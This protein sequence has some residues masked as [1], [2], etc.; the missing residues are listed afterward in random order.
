MP[1][2]NWKRCEGVSPLDRLDG[3]CG[4]IERVVVEMRRL[5]GMYLLKEKSMLEVALSPRK[6]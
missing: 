5:D 2:F 3:I 4:G 6:W 1:F